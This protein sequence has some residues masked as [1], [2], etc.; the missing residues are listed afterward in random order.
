ME[1]SVIIATHNR[2]QMLAG[3]LEA[4]QS[5]D[6]DPQSF[7]VI[8]A[9]NGS[10]DATSAVAE[11]FAKGFAHFA[12][13]FDT[14]PGQLVGWHRALA[15]A[16]SEILAFIDDDVRPG[17]RWLNAIAEIF[18]EDGTGLATGKIIPE[19]EEKP[20]KWNREMVKTWENGIWS[21]LW[22]MLDLGNAIRD[23][24]AD[25]VWGSNFLVRKRALI[26][27]G[28]FHP[29]G[30]PEHLFHFTGD[31]DVGAGRPIAGL[32]HGVRYHPDAAVSHFFPAQRNS[33]TAMR[34]WI[35]GEGLVTSYCLLRSQ[36]TNEPDLTPEQIMERVKDD[37]A[38]HAGQIERIG[39]GYLPRGAQLP[40][41]LAA[42]FET[43]GAEGFA[44]HQQAFERDPLF[45]QWVLRPHYLDLDTCYTHPDLS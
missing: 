25:F 14:R 30:M 3:T 18:A 5:Q 15:T 24:P 1:I 19:F 11:G 37:A 10:T 33:E 44:A 12:Y 45:R 32:G 31:G 38:R 17:A 35:R 4:L 42:V 20:P 36:A 6:F 43:A 39:Q 22:G 16:Q 41:E 7:E 13:L 40:G 9:D 8:V 26:E 27:A 34:R 21:S 28:G 29:G 23:I 2:C